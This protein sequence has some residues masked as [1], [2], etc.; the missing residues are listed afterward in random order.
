MK[1]SEALA[2]M[3]EILD[4]IRETVLVNSLSLDSKENYLIKGSDGYE[5]KIKCDLDERSKSLIKPILKCHRL[6]LKEERG[7]LTLFSKSDA[8]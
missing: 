1:R 7:V 2:V 3:H 5:L 6:D 4:A 8:V